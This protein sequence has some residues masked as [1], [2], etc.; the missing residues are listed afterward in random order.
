MRFR[1]LLLYAIRAYQRYLSPYKGFSCAYRVHT[2]HA[3]CSHLGFRAIR[4]Y[5]A[6]RGFSVLL[7]RTALCGVAYRRFS[8]VQKSPFFAKQKG[9]CDGDCV[10]DFLPDM[11][12][13]FL[14][15]KSGANSCDWLSCCDI[16]GCDWPGNKD[17]K[18]KDDSNVYLPPKKPF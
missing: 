16:G 3:S 13:D 4:R 7:K 17:K 18:K 9:G 2:G 11:H 10:V 12:C 8:V 5:G 6:W 1:S 14:N 15:G